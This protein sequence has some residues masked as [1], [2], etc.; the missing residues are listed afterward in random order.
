MKILVTLVEQVLSD[1]QSGHVIR[2]TSDSVINVD[3]LTYAGNSNHWQ[4]Y[5]IRLAMHSHRLISA[6]R[7]ALI[8]FLPNINPM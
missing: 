6:D 8:V 1:P 4:M 3:K 7:E 2:N 5:L